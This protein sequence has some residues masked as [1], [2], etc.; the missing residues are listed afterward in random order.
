MNE[1]RARQIVAAE[2]ARIESLLAGVTGEIRADG[3]LQR[4]QTGEYADAGTT[5]ETETVALALE[6]DLRSQLLDV[7]RAE[8]RIE[9]GTYGRSVESGTRI[10]D[11]RLEVEPL[12]ERTVEEQR[13]LERAR[14]R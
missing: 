11:D 6:A 10:P 2:R 1:T 12:A 9:A 4:Q 5:I 14:A 8:Q 13:S 3:H 7:A